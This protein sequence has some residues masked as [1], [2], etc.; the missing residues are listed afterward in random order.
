MCQKHTRKRAP[1][2]QA[3]F[4]IFESFWSFEDN[5]ST[6]ISLKDTAKNKVVGQ[7]PHE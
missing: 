4:F 6:R 1:E 2:I 5:F 7:L 3:V